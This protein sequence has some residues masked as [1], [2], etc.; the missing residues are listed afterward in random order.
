MGRR[1]Y[2]WTCITIAELYA[3]Y[4]A[5]RNSAM[6]VQLYIDYGVLYFSQNSIY[7]DTQ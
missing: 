6:E 5:T 1:I 3:A 7:P 4:T 2:E